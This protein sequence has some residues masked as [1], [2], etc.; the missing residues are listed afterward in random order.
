[1]IG[2]RPIFWAYVP[3]TAI[4]GVLLTI[5]V[6]ADPADVVARPLNLGGAT[7]FTG[8]VMAF[9]LGTSF[10]TMS[11]ER[12]A[13]GMLLG[14]CVLLS[15]SFAVIDRR[16]RAPLLPA[17]L[18]RVRRLRLG[19]L[20]GFLNTATTSS[21]LTLVTLYLQDT[22]RRSPLQAAAAMLPFSLAV[23]AGASLSAVVH[24]RLQSA[25][26]I[27]AGLTV[28]A[29][30]DLALIPSASSPWAVPVC[31]T[32]AGLG[33]GLSSVAATEMGTS[34]ELRWRGAASGIVNSC[35]QLG[36]AVGVAA[37]VLIAAATT[38][39]PAKGTGPPTVAWA[40]CAAVAAVGAVRYAIATD[41]RQAPR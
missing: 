1:M 2:W 23:I 33:I 17:A 6:P 21:A 38:G 20:G 41:S 28:I 4:L 11:A 5:S 31:V 19:A 34:V 18:L 29:L 40:V 8:A 22:L 13:G 9:V 16:A 37:L 36:T 14:G 7:A 24:R 10:I 27:A 32:G 3:L 30:A 25:G 39:V 26:T 12:A 15:L 35:A